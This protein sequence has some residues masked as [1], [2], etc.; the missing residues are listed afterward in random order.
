MFIIDAHEDIALNAIYA[1]GKDIKKKHSLHQGVSKA[2][3]CVNNNSDL[4]RLKKGGVK[5]VFVTLFGLDEQAVQS[6]IEN[7]PAAYNFKKLSKVKYGLE[8]AVEQ[9]G[10]YTRVLREANDLVEVV[11]AKKDYGKIKRSGKIGFI[12]HA[13]GIDF[14]RSLEDLD[15]FYDL[16]LRSVALTWRN[17]NLFGGGNNAKEGLTPLGGQLIRHAQKKGMVIDLAHANPATFADVVRIVRGPFM[18]SHTNC[19]A[20]HANSRNLT[21]EQIRTAAKKE[22]IIGISAITDHIG[23]ATIAHYIAH[24]IHVVK[25][26]GS[27]HVAFG[28]DFDGMVDPEDRF[29]KGFEDASGFGNVIRALEK[30]GIRGRDLENIAYRNLERLLLSTLK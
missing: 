1:T 2:G 29:M 3:F 13:E 16:G 6:L 19:N 7:P 10:Y 24:M 4:P 21:D 11:C 20:I 14:M 27:E 8:A 25:L 18:V 12:L 17:A 22:G 9:L 5:F 30:A 15:A 23:G 26:V 28:T